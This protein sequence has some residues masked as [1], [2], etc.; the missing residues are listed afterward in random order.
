MQNRRANLPF[1]NQTNAVARSIERLESLDGIARP[2]S[3]WVER[4]VAD[5]RVKDALSGTWLGHPVH[6]ML[7]DLPIGFWTSALVLDVVGGKKSRRAAQRLVAFGIL[8][9]IPTAVT[10]AADWSDTDTP[11]KRVGLVHGLL[12]TAALL[13]FVSSWRARH[14]GHHLRG[15]ALGAA[16]GAIASAAAYLGGHLVD[17]RGVGVAQTT[18]DPEPAEWT[19][20]CQELDVSERPLRAQALHESVMVV[21]DDGAIVAVAAT[22]P[23]RGA[24]LEE[25]KV[26]D[27]AV[28]CP[29]HGS[30]FRLRDGA[31]LRGPAVVP[32]TSYETRTVDGTVEIRLNP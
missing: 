7:T 10:G 20:V 15:M 17:T 25:G 1:G 14:R 11:D 27:G 24:P 22:C 29:W 3:R 12:N 18:F 6:P 8:S 5:P 30:C 31:L 23:H 4:A 16:G 28:V 32:L 9:A 26:E 19:P 13:T 21:R 2:A